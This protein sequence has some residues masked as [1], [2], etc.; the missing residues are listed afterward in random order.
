MMVSF[1]EEMTAPVYQRVIFQ[2]RNGQNAVC[3][4]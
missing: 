1:F 4:M 2:P 3:Q